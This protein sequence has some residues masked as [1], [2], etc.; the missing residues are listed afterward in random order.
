M[1]LHNEHRRWYGK[2]RIENPGLPTVSFPEPRADSTCAGLRA[3]TLGQRVY[4]L[5]AIRSMVHELQGFVCLNTFSVM[6][7]IGKYNVNYRV[8]SL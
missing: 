4:G 1:W 7:T 8:M 6:V 2:F 5:D 3:E